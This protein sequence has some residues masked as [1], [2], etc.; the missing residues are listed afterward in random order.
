M[1]FLVSVGHFLYADKESPIKYDREVSQLMTGM[2]CIN[3]SSPEAMLTWI[4]LHI[5]KYVVSEDEWKRI[6]IKNAWNY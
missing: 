5:G 1:R 3:A 4:Q 6:I 2:I